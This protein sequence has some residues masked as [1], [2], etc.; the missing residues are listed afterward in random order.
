MIRALLIGVFSL[1][2]FGATAF[3]Q[4]APHTL[5][6]VFV[7]GDPDT[8]I[9]YVIMADGFTA[10][11]QEAFRAQA[12]NFRDFL[13]GGS[14]YVRYADHFNVY[15]LETISNESGVSRPG[16]SVD[17]AL[18]SEHGCFDIDRLICADSARAGAILAAAAP[19]IN[20]H[21]RLIV[22]NT[23]TYGG[24]GGYYATTSLHSAAP[25][26]FQHEIGHSFV[27]LDDEYEDDSICAQQP[28]LYGPPNEL[29]VTV[30]TTRAASPW[31]PWI[32]DATAIPTTGTADATPGMY[33]G[34]HYCPTGVYRP[35]YNSLMCTLNRPMEQINTEEFVR[36]FNRTATALDAVS[37]AAGNLTVTRNSRTRLSVVPKIIDDLAFNVV[38]RV[39][40][41]VANDAPAAGLG[42]AAADGIGFAADGTR[43]VFDAAQHGV[44]QHTVTA[45]VRDETALVRTDINGD[46]AHEASW[47]ITVENRDTPDARLVTA[48]LP[49]ARSMSAFTPATGFVTVI[50]SGS[51]EA[52]SCT[53]TLQTAAGG[54]ATP[55]FSYRQTDA[56]T[57]APTGP[58]NPTFNI[59]AGV[60]SSFVFSATY[61]ATASNDE[62]F[63]VA[64]CG[65]S[66]PSDRGAGVNSALI[67]AAAGNSPDIVSVAATV[68]TPGVADLPS[69]GR[70]A[71]VALSA[72]NIGTAGNVTLRG[73]LGPVSLP[74]E[75][76]F[77]ETDPATGACLGARATWLD[78]SFAQNE[79][80]TFAMFIRAHGPVRFVPERFRAFAIFE[81]DRQD[82]RGGTSVAVR[83]VE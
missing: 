83:T 47:T 46:T 35:T 11:E 39:N 61:A 73:D 41:A 21:I 3:A 22:V 13:L 19:D 76:E 38:W 64:D 69:D 40:G 60:A 27:S 12:D 5:V 57:N 36:A 49:Y 7:T 10:A 33:E 59:G 70:Q 1:V 79:V 37:P 54:V 56:G 52:T 31:Q 53:L 9:N 58:E 81:Q 62:V 74:L 42:P 29:N 28:G 55:V 4:I 32:D 66:D 72:V 75:I 26:V 18:N 80:K 71:A 23:E 45:T 78:V 65:N 15:R 16:A 68:G 24:G 30:Q 82:S 6:P 34:G 63:V 20:F 48:V 8:R 17:T 43:F 44:G 50:N 2:G 67:S 14:P 25:S 51:V 77:C